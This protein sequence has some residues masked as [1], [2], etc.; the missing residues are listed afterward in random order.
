MNGP[1]FRLLPRCCV[2][3]LC[4]AWPSWGWTQGNP[5][6]PSAGALAADPFATGGPPFEWPALPNHLEPAAP[7]DDG[8]DRAV[9]DSL[10][11]KEAASLWMI[12]MPSFSEEYAVVLRPERLPRSEE[13]G[14]S[15]YI[16]SGRSILELVIVKHRIRRWKD[17]APGQVVLDIQVTKDVRRSHAVVEKAFADVLSEAWDALLK[18]TRYAETPPSFLD[19]AAYRFQSGRRLHGE[20]FSPLAGLP[21]KLAMLGE[22]LA[23]LTETAEEAR[24]ALMDEALA[25]AREII[26]ES[27]PER[28]EETWQPAKD[29]APAELPVRTEKVTR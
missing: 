14:A 23:D 4:V 7:D 29:E 13:D 10:I 28:F 3:A 20:G 2:A 8:Y 17:A 5:G 19:G 9:F 26:A 21:L 1:G 6:T 12:V 11:G 16:S 25:L 24:S 27:A 22:K 18:R 15:G